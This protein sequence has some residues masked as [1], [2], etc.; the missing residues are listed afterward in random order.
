MGRYKA[1]VTGAPGV[2]KRHHKY[3]GSVTFLERWD[4]S[5]KANATYP[6]LIFPPG[7]SNWMGP[8]LYIRP[9]TIVSRDYSLR[10][11]RAGR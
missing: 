2:S 9:V 3:T 6:F 11:C 5:T 10:N 8:R 7:S 4:M 1:V